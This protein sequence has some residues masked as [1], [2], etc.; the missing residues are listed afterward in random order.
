MDNYL[1]KAVFAMNFM[2]LVWA[3][4]VTAVDMEQVGVDC[5]FHIHLKQAFYPWGIYQK[6]TV[7]L[8]GPTS[9]IVF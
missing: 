9:A 6:V 8:Y 5:H 2:L 3:H 1:T 7:I 4:Y